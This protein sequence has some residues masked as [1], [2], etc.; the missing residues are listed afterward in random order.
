[1]VPIRT[2]A[3]CNEQIACQWASTLEWTEEAVK[4]FL[5]LRRAFTRRGASSAVGKGYST[6]E[7]RL[8]PKSVLIAGAARSIVIGRSGSGRS[9][10]AAL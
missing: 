3:E 1:M 6:A 2:L 10:F 4:A 7:D 8:Q 5:R 9:R